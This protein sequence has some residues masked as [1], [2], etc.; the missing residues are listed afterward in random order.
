VTAKRILATLA[1]VGALL[2]AAA[3][4]G[5]AAHAATGTSAPQTYYR[6]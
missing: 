5:T 4:T 2:G 6:T 3:A 1:V